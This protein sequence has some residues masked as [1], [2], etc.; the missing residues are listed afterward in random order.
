MI[1]AAVVSVFFSASVLLALSPGPDNLFVIAESARNGWRAGFL[2]TLGLC[3]GLVFHTLAVAFGL[4][5]LIRE[6]AMLFFLL[7]V[8]GAGYLLLL[9]WK[10]FSSGDAPHSVPIGVLSP[11]KLYRRGIVMNLSNPKVSLFFLAFLPQFADP[12]RGP[13]VPQFLLL[14][15]LFIVA[16]FGAFTLFSLVAGHAGSLFWQSPRAQRI[17]NRMS[18]LVFLG[19]ALKLLISVP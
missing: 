19:L 17:I 7:K 13:L 10:A 18:A 5:A 12:R 9:A 2:V 6:S 15:L 3:S 1:D 14:G 16:A 11:V 8:A 4:A